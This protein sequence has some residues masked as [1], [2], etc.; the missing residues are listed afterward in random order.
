[1]FMNKVLIDFTNC[2]GIDKL[3]YEF[4]FSVKNVYSI[5][6]KNG[7]MKTSFANT[8]QKIQQGKANEICDKIYEI[9]G[10]AIV[11]IDDNDI[12]KENIFVI[13]SYEVEYESDISPLLVRGELKESLKDVLKS[14]DKLF[15]V[16]EKDSGLKIKKTLQ[17]KTVY[18]LEPR[19][20]EDFSFSEQ[21]FLLNLENLK[22]K[23]FETDFSDIMYSIIF[24]GSIQKKIQSYEFQ[25]GID[26]FIKKIDEIYNSFSFLEKGKLTLPKLKNIRK[27]IEKDSYFVKGN[28]LNLNGGIVI[29]DINAL[30]TTLF[31]IE[32]K[33]KNLP[34]LKD[35]EQLL[36]DAKG[37]ILK[38]VIE[39]HIDIIPYLKINKL[40]EL[41]KILWMSYIAKNGVIFEE[42]YIKYLK[43]SNLIDET[44]IEDT[45]WK[46][47]LS[48]FKKRFTVPFDMEVTNLK[49]AVIG[50]SVPQ[51][52]FTF[53][54]NGNVK[55]ID[56]TRLDE[57]DTL[58]QGE[59]RALYLL[60]I[61]FDLEKI[62]A[63]NKEILL[64]VD[65]IADS[66]DYKN[67]Y[68]IIEYLYELSHMKNIK[69]IILSH[70]FDFYR[71]VSSRLSILRQNRLEVMLI[72][73][74]IN[75]YEEKYQKQPFV[76]WKKKLNSKNIIALIPFV[77]NLIE[78]GTDKEV[79][80][81]GQ[82]DFLFLTYLLHEK[83]KTDSIKFSDL[84]SIYKEYLG[85]ENFERDV[86]SSDRI[87]DCLY[88]ICDTLT[89]NNNL[90]E[91]KVL[92]SMAIRHKAEKIM[93]REIKS[94]SSIFKW[95]DNKIIK[96]GNNT[97]FLKFV[98]NSDNQT[99]NLIVGYKQ[100]ASEDNAKLMSEVSIMT[101]EN[102]HLNSFMYEP[103]LDMDIQELL[104][105]Y[106]RIKKLLG[107]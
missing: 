34:E 76:A 85:K 79:V 41:K 90:L 2:F 11:K 47:S 31:E 26:A 60:N 84:K 53:E 22:P 10:N 56:R 20:L 54:K 92:L 25:N 35:I 97:L 74:K 58:S 3:E 38:D 23:K 63:E 100:I 69:M 42:L 98:D 78:Y 32:T 73:D 104:N 13:K 52:E 39:T 16:L 80:C 46:K 61:I 14:R 50:E 37:M 68:A 18:E 44:P 7:S 49:G 88:N 9:P 57:L 6:A 91:D 105:L 12:E 70:N 93:L 106:Q 8:F 51:I 72:N 99:K 15:K 71:A 33:V 65:D 59:K 40:D 5:Y 62:K 102:I 24:D 94:S 43:F 1:M 75:L 30:D 19:I 29:S 21:S 28:N 89:E 45:P 101:S 86:N 87:T 96:S 67:K 64:I 83:A 36:S 27:S 82:K 95:E 107:E 103:L 48:I 66:F 55:K 77:R 17:G 81:H 4:D